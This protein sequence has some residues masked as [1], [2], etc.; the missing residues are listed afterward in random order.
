M[1][2][3]DVSRA[4][5]AIKLWTS[6]KMISTVDGTL[7]EICRL[8][9]RHCDVVLVWSCSRLCTCLING[10]IDDM[11]CQDTSIWALDWSTQHHF[12][13]TESTNKIIYRRAWDDGGRAR[14]GLH[15]IAD[16]R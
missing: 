8:A 16:T 9:A 3:A 5:S 13:T 4:V 15:D 14:Q 6:R 7:S 2:G 10:V 1:A 12:S 11:P